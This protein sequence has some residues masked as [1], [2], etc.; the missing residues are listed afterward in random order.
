MP[1]IVTEISVIDGENPLILPYF[2]S[3][4]KAGFPSPADD[5]LEK[6]LN[7]NDLLVKHPSSTFF[8][9]VQG[10]STQINHIHDNDILVVD[11]SITPTDGSIVVAV[12]DGILIIKKLRVIND[13]YFLDPESH[14]GEP[15][16]IKIFSGF[17]VWG[18]VTFVIHCFEEF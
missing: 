18:V 14:A 17:E 1:L 11:R 12:M 10:N 6:K 2:E 16:E 13:R 9:R 7:I 15:V 3:P 4:V 8:M 5:F